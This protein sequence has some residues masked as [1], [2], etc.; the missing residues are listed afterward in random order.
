M[1]TR[2][3]EFYVK[4]EK[5]DEVRDRVKN[6]ILPVQH[7]QPGFVDLIALSSEDEPERMVATR[8]PDH[9]INR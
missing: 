5:A 4:R 2:I 9:P 3:V 7:S 8:S 1:F 6:Q